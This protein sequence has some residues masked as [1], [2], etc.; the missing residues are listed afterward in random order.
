MSEV[1]AYINANL[2]MLTLLEDGII[3]ILK[4]MTTLEEVYRVAA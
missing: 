2:K 4:G 3:K 1:H